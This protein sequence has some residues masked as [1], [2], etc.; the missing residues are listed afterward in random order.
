M[1]ARHV[2]PDN[3]FAYNM[4]VKHGLVLNHTLTMLSIMGI[5]SRSILKQELRCLW[6]V[7]NV[8]PH[9]LSVLLRYLFISRVI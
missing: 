1:K 6:L 9:N 2:A 3:L 8:W 5:G 7:N 4:R